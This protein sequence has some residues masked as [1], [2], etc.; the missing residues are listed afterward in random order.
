MYR[1][2][3]VDD[4]EIITDSLARLIRRELPQTDVYAAY[5]GYQAMDLLSRAG[6]DVVVSDIQ[7]PGMSG[8]ELL[9]SIRTLYPACRVIFLSGH[10]DFDYAYQA[11]QYHAARYIL[12][13][14]SDDVLL[15][16]VRECIA[17]V[18]RDARRE[19]LVL[20]ARQERA[21]C[22][23]ILRREY[24][25]DLLAGPMP[26]PER[27]T[28]D[29]ER[30]GVRLSIDQTF[31]LLAGRLDDSRRAD[32]ALEVDSVVQEYLS[33]AVVCE[34]AAANPAFMLWLLQPR[35][36]MTPREALSCVRGSADGLQRVLNE[37]LG[38]SVSF[39][40]D[41]AE[42]PLTK[43]TEQAM[44][45]YHAMA[46]LLD[47]GEKHAFVYLDYFRSCPARQEKES[48]R[49]QAQQHLQQVRRALESRAQAPVQDALTGLR[50]HLAPHLEEDDL[51]LTLVVNQMNVMLFQFL[52]ERDLLD[53][54][55]D[56]G[57]LR[58][59]LDGPMAGTHR[60]QLER[61]ECLCLR[62]VSVW[63]TQQQNRSD[64]L[65]EAVDG[66]IRGHLCEELSLVILSEQVFLNPSYLSRRYKEL[67]GVNVTDAITQARMDRACELLR[68]PGLKIW[69]VAEQVGYT[70]A[71]HFNRVFRH[72]TGVTPQMWRERARS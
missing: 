30:L 3:V 70:S 63:E 66:Y 8:L 15:G 6:F 4:E 1:I 9:Q 21:R 32:D 64:S 13:S 37:S 50:L 5:S 46:C 43:L 55:R 26:E 68:D 14:E 51:D 60:Q 67:T 31:F 2:L 58:A 23:P 11:L 28:E 18:E 34:T 72:Q 38:A 29:F 54:M 61:F 12:K 35:E 42:V 20:H 22:L 40:L 48:W 57:I 27:L 47:R 36:G 49:A 71:T 56:D 24:L 33:Y 41:T 39:V 52:E 45:M 19:E 7:M 10:D 59:F 17:D 62:T 16:A 44:A 53:A 69:Q 65:V 25:S